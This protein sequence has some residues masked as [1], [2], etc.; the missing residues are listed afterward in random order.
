[1]LEDRILSRLIQ[2]AVDE[3]DGYPERE[4]LHFTST[5][6]REARQPPSRP[7]QLVLDHDLGV[8]V[9]RLRVHRARTAGEAGVSTG[10]GTFFAG[11]LSVKPQNI[12]AIPIS[13]PSVTSEVSPARDTPVAT[14]TVS[15][16]HAI[17]TFARTR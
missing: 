10:R 3:L 5:V 15:A 4:L 14:A 16:P 12:S 9:K 13:S 6:V 11:A 8:P 2:H 17:Q 1:L 7:A